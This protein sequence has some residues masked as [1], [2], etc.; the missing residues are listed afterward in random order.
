M[1]TKSFVPS[2]KLAK[3]DTIEN[4]VD[5]PQINLFKTHKPFL[6]RHQIYSHKHT[7]KHKQ[8]KRL[9]VVISMIT[10]L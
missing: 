1:N 5:Y 2:Y 3:Q 4:A 7:P 6:F 9:Q 10:F 8:T